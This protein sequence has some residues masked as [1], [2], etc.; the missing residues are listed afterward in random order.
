MKIVA[1]IAVL[2]M[3]VAL[4]FALYFRYQDKKHAKE[5]PLP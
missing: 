3:L 1:F 5:K 2:T 4:A